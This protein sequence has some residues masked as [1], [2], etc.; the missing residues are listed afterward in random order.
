MSQ[1][2]LFIT[3]EGVDGGGKST[4][5]SLLVEAL[6]AKGHEVL[7]VRDPGSTRLSEKIRLL[8]LD[9][10]NDDMSVVCELLLYEAAR[11]QLVSEKIKPALKRGMAVV[12]ERFCDSTFAYQAYGRGINT[13]LVRA[14]NQLGAC[15]LVPDATI[16]F[17]IDPSEAL[18]RAT[19]E[20]A[21]R[22]ES[23]GT[24]FQR[25]VRD[26][27]LQLAAEDPKRIRIVDAIGSVEVVHARVTAAL[28]DVV[29]L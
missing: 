28:R 15:G 22:L 9:P 24:P 5:T 18:G 17:D 29:A 6:E 4:Q 8:L 14:A 13:D 1:N 21:D 11:A 19:R 25:K 10:A 26:G 27:Y 23:E 20:G 2:G 12:C 7:R 3:L 16:V